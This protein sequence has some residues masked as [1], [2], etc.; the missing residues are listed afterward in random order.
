ML[1][2]VLPETNQQMLVTEYAY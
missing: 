1:H 2:H